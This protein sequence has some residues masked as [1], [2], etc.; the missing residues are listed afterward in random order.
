MAKFDKRGIEAKVE[1][2]QRGVQGK[3]PAFRLLWLLA[4][5]TVTLAGVVLIFFPGPA[6]VVIAIGL[7]M[8]SAEFAWASKLL[9]AA[10]D[11]GFRTSRSVSEATPSQ[12][13]LGAIALLLLVAAVAVAWW[14]R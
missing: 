10:L 1:K 8:L 13:V 2:V 12:K 11:V 3:G 9:H 7:A 6:V 14:A 5:A 4:G